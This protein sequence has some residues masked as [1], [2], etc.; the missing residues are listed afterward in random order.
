L[1]TLS[2][3]WKEIAIISDQKADDRNE[4]AF[5]IAEYHPSQE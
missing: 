2:A 1:G 4:H 3:N 5:R